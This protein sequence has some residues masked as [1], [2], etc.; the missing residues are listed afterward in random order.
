MFV[1]RDPKPEVDPV[2]LETQNSLVNNSEGNRESAPKVDPADLT[3]H[4]SLVLICEG[5]VDKPPVLLQRISHINIHM[6]GGDVAKKVEY[7]YSFFEK[8]IPNDAVF[9]KD[10]MINIIGVTEDL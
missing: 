9:Q 3:P 4:A 6:N 10:E 7:A 1:N 5:T 8:Q 2:D